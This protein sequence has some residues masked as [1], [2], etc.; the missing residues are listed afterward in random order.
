M[1][2]FHIDRNMKETLTYLD[3][4]FPVEICVDDYRLLPEHMLNSHWH[5]ELEFGVMLAGELNY[6]I[7]GHAVSL[8]EG[9][10]IFVNSN[11][12]HMAEQAEG[13]TGAVMFV[14]SFSPLLLTEHMNTLIYQKYFRPVMGKPI[15]GCVL[16]TG[17]AAGSAAI[18]ALTELH[19]LDKSAYG[20]ELRCISLLSSLWNAVLTEV[21][22]RNT[23][24][25]EQPVDKKNEE[26]AKAMLCYIREHFAEDISVD[27][28]AAQLNVSRT[29]CFRCFKRFTHKTPVEYINEY[30]LT[31]AAKLLMETSSPVTSICAA[32]GFSNSSYFSKRFKERYGDTPSRYRKECK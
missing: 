15:P 12:I 16:T 7:G 1:R 21:A 14:V 32:C 2:L 3:P 27:A 19:A 5:H 22:E 24:L 17:S 25:F 4:T 8:R 9:D 23:A 28:I 18:S 29:E 10:G 31:Q 30:R 6:F 20:F 13:K 26:R 11:T